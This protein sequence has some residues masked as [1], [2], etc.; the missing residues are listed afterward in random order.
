MASTASEKQIFFL[1]LQERELCVFSLLHFITIQYKVRSYCTRWCRTWQGSTL[2]WPILSY[3]KH[4]F[5]PVYT[6]VFV[7][8]QRAYSQL[9][10]HSSFRVDRKIFITSAFKMAFNFNQQR[11]S[12]RHKTKSIGSPVSHV[13]L[14]YWASDVKPLSQK[15][16]LETQL[17][18]NNGSLL[19]SRECTNILFFFSSEST[20]RLVS[21]IH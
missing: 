6:F 2:F 12:K 18:W 5:P 11:Q 1:F 7:Y 4:P 16:L 15:N 19:S 13:F 21:F 10:S 17:S 8:K 3:F 20:L 9:G 14:C